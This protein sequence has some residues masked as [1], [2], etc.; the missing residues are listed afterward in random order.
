MRASLVVLAL[1]ALSQLA[2]VVI[3][4]RPEA[5]ECSD[6]VDNDG[7]GLI[8]FPDDPSCHSAE[9]RSELPDCD[10]GLDNDG[11]GLFDYPADPGCRNRLDTSREDP[12][13]SDGEDNDLDTW[14]DFGQDPECTS[15]WDDDEASNPPGCGLLGIEPA[16][17]AAFAL[18]RRRRRAPTTLRG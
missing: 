17:L 1:A 16:L 6:G 10:D 2:V 12:E 15:A 7:D 5:T 4:H 13:C 14:T 8:D 9:G 11:D 3:T 18:A